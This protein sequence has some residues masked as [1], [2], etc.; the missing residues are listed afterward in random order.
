VQGELIVDPDE[1]D[2][3]VLTT[4]ESLA[5]ITDFTATITTG[6]TST[7]GAT[8]EEDFEWRFTTLDSAWGQ[9]DWLEQ[10][11]TGNSDR[12]QID[13][14]AESSALAVWEY[15]EAAGTRIWASHYT[16]VDLWG[17]PE[18]I[19]DGIEPPSNPRLAMDDAGNGFAVWEQQAAAALTNIWTNRYAVDEGW[20]TSALLQSGEITNARAPSVA[21]DTNGN[22]IAVW[23]QQEMDSPNQVVW[24]SR[25]SPGMGWSAAE[26]IDGSPT[27][28]AGTRTS[29]G[30]DDQGNAIAVWARQ[31]VPSSGGR[32]E[33]LWA[34]RYVPGFGWGIA[35]AI[36]PDSD[37][38]ARDER[39]SM[40]GNGDA[41]VVWV[42][43]DPVRGNSPEE[44]NDI[45]G[46]RFSDSGWEAP[47]RIDTSDSD[48]GEPDVAVDGSGIAHA[49]WSQ[50]DADFINVWASVYAP[51]TGWGTPE[52]IEPPNED[53]SE[54]GDAATPQV[55][56]NTDGNAF[57]VWAQVW[58][59]W[60]SV[61]SNRRDPEETQWDPART[62]LIEGAARP[63]RAPTIAADENRHAHAVWLHNLAQG[64]WVRTNRFE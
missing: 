25:Y 29:V 56:V 54:D 28:S 5:V 42:Q 44:L 63:A 26:A 27:P 3:A 18:P 17:E 14:D 47:E 32:G 50:D 12:A 58:E 41:F 52:L 22:A 8:L 49:V 10:I 19:D 35:Q 21:A 15:E 59:D 23:I 34:N 2:V 53:P 61:W 46:V 6:L 9:D 45:W 37:T 40:S 43:N 31:T 1:P 13:V 64:R 62:L 60:Q 48:K 51:G 24:A 33:V 11:G 39:L 57:V 30:M 36:K 38:R 20:G 16:R 55:D 4:S 7:G